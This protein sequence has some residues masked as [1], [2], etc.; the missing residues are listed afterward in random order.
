MISFSRSISL[1][2]VISV[3]M[4]TQ[5]V[6]F[7]NST[8][9]YWLPRLSHWPRLTLESGKA[10]YWVNTL[11]YIIRSLLGWSVQY[12]HVA[13][14]TDGYCFKYDSKI[15]SENLL[16]CLVGDS[17]Q[18]HISYEKVRYVLSSIQVV[19]GQGVLCLTIGQQEIWL[20]IKI[21][22]GF[23][24]RFCSGKRK[25]FRSL[26]FNKRQLPYIAYASK[27]TLSVPWLVDLCLLVYKMSTSVP[28]MI[29]IAPTA[30][31]QVKTSPRNKTDRRMAMATLSLSTGATC[32]TFPSCSALK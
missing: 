24:E 29:R 4:N 16:S 20:L 31:F 14:F 8:P 32:E 18:V 6:G 7:L 5:F 23:S 10:Y 30:A 22:G 25:P 11:D 17:N 3:D 1:L 2:I 21:I 15:F 12:S 9:S 28:P 27:T 13:T 19:S 26:S